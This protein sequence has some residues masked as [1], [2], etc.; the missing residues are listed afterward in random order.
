PVVEPVDLSI[1]RNIGICAHIDAGKTTIT[2]RI[3]YYTGKLYKIGEVHDGTATMDWMVQEQ[4]RGITITSAA[5]TCFWRSNQVNIIDTPGHVDFTIEVERSMRVLDGA[6]V[7]FS[8]VDGVEPQSETVWRQADRYHVPRIAVM[9]KMDRVGADF[10]GCVQQMRDRLGA[11]PLVLHLPIGAED[12]F[13]GV[14]DVVEMK[15]YRWIGGDASGANFTIEEVPASMLQETRQAHT[16]L[17]DLLTHFDDELLAAYMDGL[18]IDAAHLRPA[19]RKATISGSVVP[20]LA[21][22]ALRNIGVQPI[23]DAVSDY[24]PSPLDMPEIVGHVPGEDEL[25]ARPPTPEAPLSALAFKI[26]TDPYMGKLTYLRIYSG[27]MLAG[28]Y[29]FNVNKGVKE[30]ISRMVR[31]HANKREDITQACAGD[32]VAVVGI[33]KVTTGDT[34][35]DEKQPI[36]LERI[37]FPDPVIDIAIEPATQGDQDKLTAALTKMLE[38]DPSLRMK[39]D[40][41]TGQTLIRGMGELHLDIVVDRLQR[42]HKVNAVVGKPQVSYCET[43]TKSARAEGRYVKQ[44][45]G[46]GMY[47]HVVLEVEPGERNAGLVFV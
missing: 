13:V 22:A 39:T 16:D 30:R 21:C 8:A 19:I 40:T 32:I 47:G 27:T 18:E 6:V 26:Q 24:L 33:R 34:I 42:E 11:K 20:V 3:L 38:E 35:C 7:V 1:L 9:N 41:D 4:E 25:I 15:A 44:S 14:V 43:I 17:V 29:A 37:K 46:R 36:E 12:T 2:E 5:T 31:M 10:R 28:T 23:L 45:G